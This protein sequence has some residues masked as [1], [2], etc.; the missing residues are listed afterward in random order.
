MEIFGL[1]GEGAQNRISMSSSRPS[2]ATAQRRPDARKAEMVKIDLTEQHTPLMRLAEQLQRQTREVV[3]K[4]G[5]KSHFICRM[6]MRNEC[7]G[8]PFDPKFLA[9]P[10]EQNRLTRY[11]C[12]NLEK[13]HKHA[14]L[15]EPDLGIHIDLIEPETYEPPGVEMQHEP[16]DAALLADEVKKKR[17]GLEAD[18]LKRPNVPW[19]QKTSYYG[20]EDL[21]QYAQG[22]K[23]QP[24]LL[25]PEAE[26]ETQLTP[27]QLA[28]RLESSFAAPSTLDTMKHPSK[29]H[30]TAV[31]MWDLMPDWETWAN[32][33]T[34]VVFDCDPTACDHTVAT[35]MRNEKTKESVAE[36]DRS[37]RVLGSTA[38][39]HVRRGELPPRRG[40]IAAPE[41]PPKIFGFYLPAPDSKKRKRALEDGDAGVDGDDEESE[42]FWEYNCVREHQ[43]N[44]ARKFMDEWNDDHF[45]I[46]FVDAEGSQV[47]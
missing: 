1:R 30:L 28:E 25:A 24:H 46:A 13:N 19:L 32:D 10:S 42:D 40:S 31:K 8:L 23:V 37:R 5:F 21:F 26:L 6:K 41:E 16:E 39:M 22:F 17:P 11:T 44:E 29:P 43:E 47:Y 18:K 38:F 33:Y 15:T 34:E 45:V 14:L 2:G 35:E 27:K 4:D 12:T 3:G 36:G 7:P 20:N 9:Y